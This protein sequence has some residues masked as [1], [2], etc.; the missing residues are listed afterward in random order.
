MIA[1]FD[2]SALHCACGS[3]AVMCIDPGADAEMDPVFVRWVRRPA[4]PARAWC[5]VCFASFSALIPHEV[6]R[7]RRRIGC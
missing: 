5:A 7:K 3:S 4:V 1:A 2:I 6:Q